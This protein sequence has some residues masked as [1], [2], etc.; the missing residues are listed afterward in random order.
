MAAAAAAA[1]TTSFLPEDCAGDAQPE[2][3]DNGSGGNNGAKK[4]AWNKPSNGATE[5]GP[6]MGAFSWPAL[7][8][9]TRAS[10]KSSS[11]SLKTLS[12]VS[13]PVSQVPL[14]AFVSFSFQFCFQCVFND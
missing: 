13:V 5:A 4:P 1:A 12:D 3:S 8:E 10:P 11:E 6:V 7:S 14:I 9:S 2:G